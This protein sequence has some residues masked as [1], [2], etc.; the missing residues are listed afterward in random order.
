MLRKLALATTNAAIDS[1]RLQIRDADAS[2]A[3]DLASLRGI[4]TQVT[5]SQIQLTIQ[6]AN[7]APATPAPRG[8]GFGIGRALHVAGRVLVVAAGVSL[9]ALA[10]LV[11]LGLL[12]GFAAWVARLIVR[13]RREQALDLV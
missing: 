6:A 2:I 4:M 9:I 8:G 11:P 5:H 1:L 3:S 7:P 12:V 13:R 10:G